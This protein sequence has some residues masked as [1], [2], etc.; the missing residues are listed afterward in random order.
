MRQVRTTVEI[1][2]GERVGL[3]F[4]PRLYMFKGEQGITFK[5]DT[6]DLMQ[7]YALYADLMY[8]AALNLWTLEG[9]EKADAPFSRADFHEFSAT[10]P[11]AFGR[12]LNIAL[13]ALTGK[14]MDMFIAESK[15]A[16]ETGKKTT[17]TA[18]NSKKKEC[19]SIPIIKR[20]KRFLSGG[21]D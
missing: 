13:E 18:D 1:R 17:K 6:N 9:R 19:S 16:L 8:C 15:K 14:S 2:Q 21:A 10:N 5:A 7:V 12:A 20:L 4:T 11:Q 3:L